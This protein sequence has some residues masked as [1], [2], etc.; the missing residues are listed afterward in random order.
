V[1]DPKNEVFL[2]NLEGARWEKRGQLKSS[3][4]HRRGD[5]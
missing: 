4:M 3:H 2:S 5:F 1:L